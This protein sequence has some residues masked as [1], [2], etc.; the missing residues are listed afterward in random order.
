MLFC[1]LQKCFH[2]PDQPVIHQL[3]QLAFVHHPTGKTAGIVRERIVD[4]QHDQVVDICRR[5]APLQ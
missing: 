1:L 5:D 2:Q 3:C 4:V